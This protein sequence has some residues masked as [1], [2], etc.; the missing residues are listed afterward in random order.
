MTAAT[1][2]ASSGLPLTLIDLTEPMIVLAGRLL[3][4]D[5]GLGDGAHLLIAPTTIAH[6]PTEVRPVLAYFV[7]PRLLREAERDLPGLG[8]PTAEVLE[9]IDASPVF[10][11]RPGTPSQLATQL[12]RVHLRATVTPRPGPPTRPGVFL[13]V[14]ARPG[15]VPVRRARRRGVCRRATRGGPSLRCRQRR[16]RRRAVV[17]RGVRRDRERPADR[18]SLPGGDSRWPGGASGAARRQDRSMSWRD[19]FGQEWPSQHR[20]AAW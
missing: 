12:A 7:R 11:C 17:G 4:E 20:A 3:P 5:A 14:D 18:H 19:V 9:V 15:R 1:V 6:S 2:G 16:S 13:P 10:V 8:V